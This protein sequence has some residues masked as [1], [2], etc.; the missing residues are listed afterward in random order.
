M[1]LGFLKI[2]FRELFLNELVIDSPKLAA[3]NAF[4]TADTFR[5]VGPLINFDVDRA[6]LPAFVAKGAFI[7]KGDQP[8]KADL[9]EQSKDRS[10]RTCCPAEGTFAH[11]HPDNEQDK[12]RGFPGEQEA[13]LTSDICADGRQRKTSFQGSGRANPFAKPGLA[14]PEL[15][16]DK[17]R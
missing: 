14:K 12:N 5:A 10:Q 4:Q 15:I 8:E 3:I 17:Q 2:W 6:I 1:G 11:Y 13:Q 7:L 16:H 9:V